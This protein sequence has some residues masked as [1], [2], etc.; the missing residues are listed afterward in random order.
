MFKFENIKYIFF[1]LDNTLVR[2]SPFISPFFVWR[3]AQIYQES[4]SFLKVIQ[5][6]VSV[7]K[8]MRELSPN[9]CTNYQRFVQSFAHGSGLPINTCLEIDQRSMPHVLCSLKPF[10]RPIPAAQSLVAQLES[11]LTLMLATNALWPEYFAWLRL[12]WALIDPRRFLLTS[13]AHNMKNCKPHQAYYK[14]LISHAQ[15]LPELCLYIGDSYTKD[16]PAIQVGITTIILSDKT[17]LR[18]IKPANLQSAALY[19]ADYASIG[20]LFGICL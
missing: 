17:G 11:S 2:C 1:D 3:L 13:H 8:N 5:G 19:E 15:I 20:K 4:C 7:K 10:F 9:T 6:L 12:K 18:N 16:S 14:E